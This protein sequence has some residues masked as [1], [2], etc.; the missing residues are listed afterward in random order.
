LAVSGAAL[1]VVKDP[2]PNLLDTHGWLLL[3]SGEIAR[4]ILFL[5][6]AARAAPD[7]PL[8]QSHLA[9]AY[10][11]A[12]RSTDSITTT[13]VAECAEEVASDRREPEMIVPRLQLYLSPTPPQAQP[14][15]PLETRMTHQ[16]VRHLEDQR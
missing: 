4:S 16:R 13:A 7:D 15:A 11:K 9:A 6:R 10:R 2:D 5:E 8:I 12:G 14:P 1:A 3:E